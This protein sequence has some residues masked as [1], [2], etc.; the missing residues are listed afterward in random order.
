MG[1]ETYIK[2]EETGDITEECSDKTKKAFS[3]L[4]SLLDINE[5]NLVNVESKLSKWK[6]IKTT[7]YFMLQA[8]RRK[9]ILSLC[10]K[11]KLKSCGNIVFSLKDALE[12]IKILPIVYCVELLVDLPRVLHVNFFILIKEKEC[13]SVYRYEPYGQFHGLPKKVNSLF[14]N[15]DIQEYTFLNSRKR[16]IQKS[17]QGLLCHFYSILVG[18]TI[19]IILDNE[20]TESLTKNKI[21]NL[22]SCIEDYIFFLGEKDLPNVLHKIAYKMKKVL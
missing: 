12:K 14:L 17:V 19:M 15:E 4:F 20:D 5:K 3:K 6:K 1:N 2:Y 18:I 8:I 16:G 11:L 21:L 10:E 7:G 22:L 13:V 9:S